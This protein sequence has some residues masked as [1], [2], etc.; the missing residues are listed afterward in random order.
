VPPFYEQWQFWLL[1]LTLCPWLAFVSLYA[2]RS[3]W[4]RWPIGRS[5]MLSKIVIVA[6]LINGIVGRIWPSYHHLRSVV[7]VVLIGGS[8]LA[9]C[10]QLLNLRREQRQDRD[11]PDTPRRRA[12]DHPRR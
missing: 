8:F 1:A 11:A 3:P 9:G 12:T 7:Y 4:W 5:L 6:V 2:A 10:Y